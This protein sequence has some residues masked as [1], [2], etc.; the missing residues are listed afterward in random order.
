MYKTFEK[1]AKNHEQIILLNIFYLPGKAVIAMA[2][3][4]N[5]KYLVKPF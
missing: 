3:P 5:K 4:R 2:T 1:V